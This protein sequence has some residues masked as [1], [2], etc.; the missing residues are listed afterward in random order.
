MM[1]GSIDM[2]L[3]LKIIN[4]NVEKFRINGVKA[5]VSDFGDVIADDDMISVCLVEGYENRK[6]TN[7]K[8]NISD[9]ENNLIFEKLH[10]G[11]SMDEN[12]DCN[13]HFY[14]TRGS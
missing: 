14:Y 7:Q 13:G 2:K 12:I 3:L 8:Y 10:N 4:H 9:D 5:K 11:I 1:I 6:A